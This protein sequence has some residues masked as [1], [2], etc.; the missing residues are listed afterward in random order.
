MKKEVQPSNGEK[1]KK[2]KKKLKKK[3]ANT[4]G[5]DIQNLYEVDE[6]A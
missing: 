1:K 5:A 3:G 2:K 6:Q 4:G